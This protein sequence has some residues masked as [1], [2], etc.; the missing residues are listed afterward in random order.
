MQIT[1]FEQGITQEERILQALQR[2]EKLTALDMLHRFGSYQAAARIFYLR[3]KGHPIQSKFIKTPTGKSIVQY[4]LQR[5]SQSGATSQRPD[6]R[7]RTAPETSEEMRGK[8]IA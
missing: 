7:Q 5:N 4:F 2:G 1:L 8:T 3:Q 6:A